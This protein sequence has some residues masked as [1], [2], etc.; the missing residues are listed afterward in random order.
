MSEWG[1]MGKRYVELRFD[2][3]PLVRCVK[4]KGDFKCPYERLSQMNDD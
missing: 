3:F 2:V 1:W 4:K